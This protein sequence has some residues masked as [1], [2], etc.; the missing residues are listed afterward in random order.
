VLVNSNNSH[1]YFEIDGTPTDEVT[2]PPPKQIHYYCDSYTLYR[3]ENS[4]PQQPLASD[5]QSVVFTYYN[6]T[7]GLVNPTSSDEAKKIRL[8]KIVLTAKKQGS[9][10]SPAVLVQK[11]SLRS[12]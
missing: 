12:Y 6:S 10:I 8:V 5:I 11:I 7:G 2:N 1:L 9:T 4:L 3:Q